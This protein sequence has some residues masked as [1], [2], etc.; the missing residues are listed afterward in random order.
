MFAVTFEAF[1]GPEQ[2]AVTERPIPDP[3][4][5][6]V[7]V[8]IIAAAVNPTDLLMLG[9]AQA[10][11]MTHLT[12]PYVAG[13]E[14]SGNV[15]AVG[16]TVDIAPGTRV[17]GVVN[18][19]RPEGGAHAAYIVVPAAS[20][21]AIDMSVDALAAATVPMNALTSVLAL[22]MLALAPGKTLLVTGG[23]GML[24]GSAIQLAK[25]RGLRVIA[26]VRDDKAALVRDLGAD[27]VVPRDDGMAAAVRAACPEGVDGLIDGALIGNEVSGLVRDGGGAVALR[28]SHPIGDDR[29]TCHVVSVAKGFEREDILRDLSCLLGQGR[30]RPRLAQGG[31]IS[32]R[33]AAKAYRLT[34][35]GGL[36]GRAVLVFDAEGQG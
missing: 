10:K 9:G 1:G 12:P 23:A 11:M 34:Q 17:M 7:V 32:F 14:F 20:V 28:S 18:P 30:F 4:A 8:R 6:E 36:D 33:D 5:G 13:M 21:V 22:D 31:A 15:H 3:A 25:A 26:N 35:N 27:L 2:L 19:R 29:L 16:E 24:G